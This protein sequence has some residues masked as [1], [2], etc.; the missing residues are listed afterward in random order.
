MSVE[1]VVRKSGEKVWRARWRQDGK[2]RAKT[3]TTRRDALDFDAE[4][5]R[6]ARAGMLA[7]LDAGTETLDEYV[8][9]TWAPTYGPTLAPKTL[10]HYASL[11]DHHI[12]PWLG[13]VRLRDLTPE[14]VARWQADRL[15]TG[16]GPVAVRYALVLLGAIVQRAV[17][18]QRIPS[19]SV[20]LVR[21][22]RSPRREEV[23]PLSPS[24]VEAVRAALLSGITTEP[25]RD[26]TLVSVLAYS[27]LRPGEALALRW[28]DVR[29]STLL[30]QRALSL[31]KEA[32][33]KTRQ[34]R[35]VRLLSPLR[36]D[37]AAWRLASGRPD[38]SSLVFPGRHGAPWT[39]AAYQSWRRQ[40]FKAA[41]TEA[42]LQN[43]RPLDLRHSFASLLLHEGRSVIYVAR[44]LGHDARLT[45]TRYGH[46]IDEYED[47]SHLDAETA[48]RNAR[49][50]GIVEATERSGRALAG[51]AWAPPR[52]DS[53]TQQWGSGE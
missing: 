9:D 30:V 34:H 52:N 41:L 5:R 36:G 51:L 26:A 47:Q 43:A 19:N 48:I 1:P 35:T 17:E 33:T 39:E 44:Q 28:G 10:R 24:T 7:L 27:G 15:A 45:L 4:R 21:K 13:S 46:V 8:A 49:E 53:P 23:V 18:A 22:A 20:R 31:G 3:F 6:A 37:L 40:S 11:Y 16:A 14:L 38:E 29:D 32:D 42:G 50:G 25:L 12:S 2:N